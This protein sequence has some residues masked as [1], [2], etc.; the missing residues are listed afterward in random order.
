LVG[1]WLLRI[2]L[3]LYVFART[4]STLST[5]I[6]LL[7]STVP[8]VVIAPIAGTLVDR[9][10]RRRVMV[11][12][13]IGRSAILVALLFE[14]GQR[15]MWV[16][17]LCAAGQACLSQFFGPA[18]NVLLASLVSR[19][20]LAKANAAVSVGS[21][22]ALLGGPALGGLVYAASGLRL[23]TGLD[24]ASYLLSAITIAALPVDDASAPTTL[25]SR[26]RLFGHFRDGLSLVRRNAILRALFPVTLVL[27]V[28]GG[29]LAV[30]I[31]PFVRVTLHA[32]GTDYGLVLSAQAVGGLVG[33]AMATRLTRTVQAPRLAMAASLLAM[34]AA[35]GF[36]AVATQWWV[37]AL[38]LGAGGVPTTISTLVANMIV[39]AVPVEDHRGRIAGLYF[40]V[41]AL[42]AAV[43][44]LCAGVLVA[45]IDPAG[46]VA[47]SA[48]VFACSGLL[49]LALWPGWPF[50]PPDPKGC[51][52]GNA[53]NSNSANATEA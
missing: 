7:A 11:G 14:P 16:V 1:D 40:G 41:V 10:D 38:C 13:D 25:R 39:Q 52:P 9:W 30:T 5:G 21:E 34:A 46:A 23:A 37:V 45:A 32:S 20:D 2:A 49:A 36:M 4:G 3:P 33:A 26:G 29:I 31:V 19:D 44:A 50:S 22:L 27:F 51:A 6:T 53:A 43:G 12:T 17:Y 42:G 48:G 15:A 28:G 47:V 24:I 8:A 18:R 35:V